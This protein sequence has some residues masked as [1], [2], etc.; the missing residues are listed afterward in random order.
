MNVIR[1]SCA[2]E[3]TSELPKWAKIIPFRCTSSA[4]EPSSSREGDIG[5]LKAYEI[6][7]G[8]LFY[9]S[10]TNAELRLRHGAP[11]KTLAHA[12]PLLHRMVGQRAFAFEHHAFR[13]LDFE[14]ARHLISETRPLVRSF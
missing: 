10:K 9:A 2:L 12:W 5:V 8:T 14:T 4:L 7:S 3:L 1:N 13:K 6:L 11:N